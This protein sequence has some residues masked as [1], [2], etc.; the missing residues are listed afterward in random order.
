MLTKTVPVLN[1]IKAFLAI[2]SQVIK[3]MIVCMKKG[4]LKLMVNHYGNQPAS[5]SNAVDKEGNACHSVLQ[6]SSG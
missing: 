3:S 5:S 4:A 1:I 2:W 6:I